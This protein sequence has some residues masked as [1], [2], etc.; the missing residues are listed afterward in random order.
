MTGYLYFDIGIILSCI[1]AVFIISLGVLSLVSLCKKFIFDESE[2]KNY[3]V[4]FF[5]NVNVKLGGVK[6]F[7]GSDDFIDAFCSF[8]F[9]CI[10]IV[11]LILLWL[12]ATI[13]GIIVSI[14]FLLRFIVRTSK[15]ISKLKNHG[16]NN[17]GDMYYIDKED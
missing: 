10:F 2:C 7:C 13:V 9:C 8:L 16:H 6:F 14:L 12:P 4:D 11:A 15:S 5:D 3:Y 17:D 1:F